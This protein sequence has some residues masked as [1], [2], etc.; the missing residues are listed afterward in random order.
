MS[1]FISRVSYE[2]VLTNPLTMNQYIYC[3]NN[4]LGYVDPSGFDAEDIGRYNNTHIKNDAFNIHEMLDVSGAIQFPVIPDIFDAVNMA[5]YQFEGDSENAYI[6]YFAIINDLA[7]GARYTDDVL[8]EAVEL[9]GKGTGNDVL[10]GQK[11]VSQFFSKKGKF[12]GASIADVAEQLKAGTLSPD[13]L[14]IEYIVR[15][16]QKIT[17]NNRSLT[18][19][20]QAGLK[21]TVLIDKTGNAFLEKHLTERLL[22]MGGSPSSSM[23]IRTIKET[24]DLPK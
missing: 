12:K 24:V 19:L 15:D 13:D 1:R 11:G 3:L 2:G 5:L 22:E 16:G 10:F 20:S 7:V 21:P 18:A 14:P 4:P 9:F 6:S 8:E 23:F 17:L